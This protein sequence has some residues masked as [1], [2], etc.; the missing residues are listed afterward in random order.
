MPEDDARPAMNPQALAVPD[1]AR[2]L[3][4]AGGVLVTEAMLQADLNAGAPQNPD[5]T[6]NLV[7]YAAWLVR[8]L[9]SSGSKNGD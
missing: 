1:A 7:V 9:A 2:M 8:K 6:V 5:G 3:S 4:K